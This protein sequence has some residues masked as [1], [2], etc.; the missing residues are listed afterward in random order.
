MLAHPWRRMRIHLPFQPQWRAAV[1]AGTKTTTVRTKRYG[2]PGDTFEVDGA[3]LTLVEVET[4]PLA[5]ARDAVWREE[6]MSSPEEFEC[7]WTQN[8][9]TRGFRGEDNVWVHR[10]I[11]RS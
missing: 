3:E 5:K 4:M 8:H 9:P 11:R 7:V 2:A 1:L 10:F 6:G